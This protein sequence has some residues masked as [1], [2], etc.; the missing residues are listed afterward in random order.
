MK[1]FLKWVGG[2]TR[3]IKQYEQLS[4][5]PERFNNYYEPFLGGGA[6]FFYLMERNLVKGCILNDLNFELMSTYAQVKHSVDFVLAQVSLFEALHKQSPSGEYFNYLRSQHFIDLDSSIQKAAKFI[7]LNKACRSGIWRVNRKGQFNVPMGDPEQ[8]IFQPELLIGASDALNRAGAILTSINGLD[9]LRIMQPGDFAFID[10]PY[11]D[12]YGEYNSVKFKEK[13]Q[14]ELRDVCVDLKKRECKFL[15]SNSD[16]AFIRE[17]YSDTS[18]FEIHEVERSGQIN[19]NA[20]DRGKVS[21][22]AITR[23]EK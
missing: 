11:H 6:M 16:T 19:S 22:L 17:L 5:I 12:T 15:L 23:V 9:I 13:H 10:P 21:E 2:K 7:Y 20:K 8:T 14:T 3:L 18:V 1:P 4:L